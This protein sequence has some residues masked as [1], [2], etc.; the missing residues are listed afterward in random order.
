MYVWSGM[1]LVEL[2]YDICAINTIDSEN[3]TK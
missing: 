2:K 3:T 1:Q